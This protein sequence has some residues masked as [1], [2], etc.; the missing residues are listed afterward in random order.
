MDH[1][2]SSMSIDKSLK[3]ITKI[4]EST[5]L[6]KSRAH[7]KIWK[8]ISEKSDKNKLF[9]QKKKKTYDSSILSAIYNFTP[10]SIG[11]R[12]FFNDCSLH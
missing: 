11:M 8:L 1:S 6:Y 9:W 5:P 2:E 12:A 7:L 10:W 4:K 3:L